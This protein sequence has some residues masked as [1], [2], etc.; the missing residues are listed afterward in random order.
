MNITSLCQKTIAIS[1]AVLFL[2]VPLLLT[3]WNYELF[4]YNKMMAVYALTVIIVGAWIIKMIAQKEIRIA[5]TPLDIPILL[6]LASQLVSSIFSIDP[7]VSW[8]GYYSRFNGGMLSILCYALLYWAFVSN[9]AEELRMMNKQF[10]QGSKE[11]HPLLI[12]NSLFFILKVALAGATVVVLYGIAERFGIDKHLWVQDVQNRVFSTMGQ[13][14]WLAA[15]IIPLI[16]IIKALSVVRI[17]NQEFKI[18]RRI[19]S[20]STFSLF[21]ILDALFFT[22]LLFTRSRSGLFA[23]AITD[24]IFWGLI[25]LG[26]VQRETK[27][28]RWKLFQAFFILHA[29]FF[30]V[31]FLNGTHIETIDKYFTLESWKIRFQKSIPYNLSL[32]KLGIPSGVEGPTTSPAPSG[33]LLESGG[34]E[35]GTIRKHVWQ[36]AINA[37]RSSPKT[38]A[39]GTGTETFAFAFYQFRPVGH[40]LTSEWDFLYNKAHNEYLNY[41]ATTGILGVGSYL[42]FIG[43][44]IWWM[45]K[46][47]HLSRSMYHAAFVIALFAGWISILVTNFFGFSVVVTNIFLFLLPAMMFVLSR[48]SHP[49]FRIS[50]QLNQQIS[51]LT[52]LLVLLVLLSLLAAHW[53]A[54]T[55]FASGYRMTHAGQ[56]GSGA[57]FLKQAVTINPIEPYYYDELGSAYSGM[58]SDAIDAKDATIAAT[59]IRQSLEASDHALSISPHNVNFWKTRTKIYY[60]FSSFDQAFNNAA[61]EALEQAQ[62]LSPNDPKI[63]YNLSILYGRNGENDKAITL[64]TDTIELKPNYRDAYYALWVFYIEVKKPDLARFIAEEYLKKVDPGDK[65]FL[66]KV[67]ESP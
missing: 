9:W 37:W 23:F 44:F 34:T 14:N 30:L 65:E 1:F 18:Q 31:V 7:H 12:L 20:W 4:E 45:I 15:Y 62:K 3:P 32:D 5:R 42:L 41:L 52:V 53:Y 22:A 17:K 55:L 2:V 19:K 8:F 60:L 56:Y 50:L 49:E 25:L 47:I 51:S 36:G 11:N 29:A 67:N 43:S 33:T 48:H 38:L 16:P 59:L 35:S 46:R 13:P 10:A 21:I 26:S 57:A 64:L 24:V 39:I 63:T 28:F 27:V 66:S 58:V 6:F 61:I 54:D 40:N